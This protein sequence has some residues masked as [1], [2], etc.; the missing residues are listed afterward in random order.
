MVG[1]FDRETDPTDGAQCPA[2]KWLYACD[3]AERVLPLFERACPLDPRA[4]WI[5]EVTRAQ[6]TRGFE[7]WS[8]I[9]ARLDGPGQFYKDTETQLGSSRSEYHAARSVCYAAFGYFEDALTSAETAFDYAYP[10]LAKCDA[11]RVWQ[12]RHLR[13]YTSPEAA[14]GD[15]QMASEARG[16]FPLT[17]DPAHARVATYF[18]LERLLALDLAE[19]DE[20]YRAVLLGTRDPEV[21]YAARASALERE[22]AFDWTRVAYS[23]ESGWKYVGFVDSGEL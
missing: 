17:G 6:R 18:R 14:L 22:S 19:D 21:L 5:L 20:S 2:A 23:A 16:L 9:F 1:S 7:F 3:C 12:D 10:S 15:A 4:R 8:S 13:L 11:E